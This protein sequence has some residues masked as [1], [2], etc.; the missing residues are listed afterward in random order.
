MMYILYQLLLIR[1]INNLLCGKFV[2]LYLILITD[3]LR[4]VSILRVAH[5]NNISTVVKIIKV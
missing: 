5:N 4:D 1:P 3:Y 2:K